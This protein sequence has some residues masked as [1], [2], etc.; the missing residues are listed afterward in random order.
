MIRSINYAL[1]Y[2]LLLIIMIIGLISYCEMAH[3]EEIT[4]SE[5]ADHRD[6]ARR[7]A[8]GN[9]KT[10]PDVGTDPITNNPVISYFTKHPNVKRLTVY[11]CDED[12]TCTKKYVSSLHIDR[13]A[14]M[15]ANRYLK[16]LDYEFKPEPTPS[17]IITYYDSKENYYVIMESLEITTL[18]FT[19]IL[20]KSED[21]QLGKTTEFDLPVDFDNQKKII[22][23]MLLEV[24][25][26]KARYVYFQL[27]PSPSPK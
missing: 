17:N 15:N 10:L 16:T 9:M 13:D 11:R 4:S 21:S 18:K 23:S 6:M 24:T 26:T 12:P 20:S 27:I 14:V 22:G 8:S 19:T 5:Y 3:S 1:L 25:P 2:L 7:M